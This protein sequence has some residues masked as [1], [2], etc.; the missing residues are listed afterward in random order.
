MAFCLSCGRTH[1]CHASCRANGCI[2]GL[3]VRLVIDGS[4]AETWGVPSDEV[5]ASISS[6]GESSAR[7]SPRRRMTSGEGGTID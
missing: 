4:L 3:C 5:I 1:F 6:S 7:K 2:A